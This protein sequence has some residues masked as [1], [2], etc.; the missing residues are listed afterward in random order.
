MDEHEW[1]ADYRP[2][3]ARCHV[4]RFRLATEVLLPAVHDWARGSTYPPIVRMH[5]SA[6][7]RSHASLHGNMDTKSSLYP[8]GTYLRRL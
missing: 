7:L 8:Q 5:G 4:L 3:A 6:S 1:L 2:A